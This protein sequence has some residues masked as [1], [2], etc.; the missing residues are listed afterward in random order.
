MLVNARVQQLCGAPAPESLSLVLLVLLVLLV[1]GHSRMSP[2]SGTLVPGDTR[3]SGGTQL[4][5]EGSRWD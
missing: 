1:F 2:V 3:A 4:P 5:I